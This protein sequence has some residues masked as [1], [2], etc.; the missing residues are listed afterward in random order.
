MCINN[1]ILL[2]DLT[3]PS[4]NKR[5]KDDR[6]IKQTFTC[7]GKQLEKVIWEGWDWI[8]GNIIDKELTKDFKYCP[9][10]GSKLSEVKEN[11]V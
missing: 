9:Y 7:C 11:N 3:I 2:E 8:D 10:C 4:K 5:M 1:K 6:I